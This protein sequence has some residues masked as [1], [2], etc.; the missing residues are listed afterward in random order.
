MA[1]TR[2]NVDRCEADQVAGWID[3]TGSP[4]PLTIEINGE[5]VC[6]LSPTQYRTDLRE[7]GLGDGKRAFSFPLAGYLSGP[8][9]NISLNLQGKEIYSKIVE[10]LGNEIFS[11]TSPVQRAKA[12]TSSKEQALD[13]LVARELQSAASRHLPFLPGDIRVGEDSIEIEAYAGA[14]ENITQNMAFFVNGHRFDQVEYP[15]TDEALQSKFS[16]IHGMGLVV[17]A[18]ITDHLHD[19]RAARFL[20]FDASSTGYF[21]PSHWR[22]A[23]HFM[24]PAFERFP[25]PPEPNI[26]R[27]IGDVSTTRFAIGGATI[28]KNL[29]AYLDEIGHTWADF[30][31]ILDWGCGS[32]RVTRYL[33]SETTSTVFGADIDPDNIAWCKAAYPDG[34]FHAV[35]LRPP[36]R[37][38][39]SILT[40]SAAFPYSLISGRMISGLGWVSCSA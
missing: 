28:F 12:E 11:T 8:I 16:E 4:S 2:F 33:L 20:R 34:E 21:L 10:S 40:L 23:I 32:G 18:R 13:Q 9:N 19:L 6:D 3:Q 24:N 26:Q 22:S 25:M 27:V 39:T 5:W 1:L 31:R 37:C 15:I 36:P 30:P 14:P 17:R 38:R 29:E 35:S 7:A